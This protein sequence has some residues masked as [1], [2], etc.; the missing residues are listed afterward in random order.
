MRNLTK[1]G[2]VLI[3]FLGVVKQG[4]AQIIG[5]GTISCAQLSKQSEE[6]RSVTDLALLA[7]MQGFESS[8]NVFRQRAGK[9]AKRLD[10]K[11]FSPAL[12]VAYVLTYC[13]KNPNEPAF[14]GMIQAFRQLPSSNAV[15]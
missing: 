4:A 12:Q 10:D 9:P 13:R 1:I 15:K 11:K 14:K 8:L 5:I 7:W 2:I 3:L 6:T